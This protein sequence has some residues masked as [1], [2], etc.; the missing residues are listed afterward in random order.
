MA[1]QIYNG[2]KI[3]EFVQEFLRNRFVHKNTSFRVHAYANPDT[4]NDVIDIRFHLPNG[5]E[6]SVK[7]EWPEGTTSFSYVIRD[8]TL[9]TIMLLLG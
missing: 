9:A 8:E 3:C 6:Q 7:E 4:R 5:E 2:S 1:T